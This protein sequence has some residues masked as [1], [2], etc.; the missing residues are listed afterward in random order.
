MTTKAYAKVNLRLKVLGITDNNYHLLQ[1]V[2]TKI[3][4]YDKI[5]IKKTKKSGVKVDM[6]G[7]LEQD[8]LVYKV[9]NKML[10]E[11][12]LS[13]GLK[14]KIV[15][16]IPIGAGLAGGSADAAAVINAIDKMYKLNLTIEEKRKIALP[17]GTD[18]V[19]CLENKLSLVEGIGE[20]IYH[21]NRNIKSDVLII[22]PSF[23]VLTKDIFKEYDE[24]YSFSK[25]LKKKELEDLPLSKLLENDLESVVF[26]KYPVIKEIKESL[27]DKGYT[28]VMMSGSGPTLF[29]LGKKKELKKIYIDVLSK[30]SDYNIYL[31]KTK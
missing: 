3:A 16:R 22:N 23:S 11:F 31:I 29:A 10:N 6:Q 2:N 18:I 8:N 13:L 14:I 5:I 7:V 9:A 20:Y 21:L 26:E 15:K 1:M 25:A 19:Y 12:N 24:K 28:Y 4:L 17:F 27:I 30:Y